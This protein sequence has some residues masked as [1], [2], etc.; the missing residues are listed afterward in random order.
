MRLCEL[1]A[2]KMS[3]MPPADKPTWPPTD[4]LLSWRPKVQQP[5]DSLST[6]TTS[7]DGE[8]ISAWAASDG[9]PDEWG[10][11]QVPAYLLAHV[12][13]DAGRPG[14]GG[15]TSVYAVPTKDEDL[16]IVITNDDEIPFTSPIDRLRDL[17]TL[18]ELLQILDETEVEGEVFGIGH[19]TREKNDLEHREQLRRFVTIRSPLYPAL[20]QLDRS[21]LE[22]WISERP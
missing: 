9:E 12:E 11:L 5:T 13:T 4:D 18:G 20:E 22:K 10:E 17:P 2:G 14:G 16:R 21:R 6:S 7:S 15:I 8:E 3:R 1:R 19:P